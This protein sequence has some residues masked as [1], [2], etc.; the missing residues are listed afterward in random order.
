MNKWF[1]SI[2]WKLVSTYLLLI[3]VLL[4]PLNILVDASLT[5]YFIN[6]KKQS[7]LSQGTI[8]ADQIAPSFVAYY[9][10]SRFSYIE[11]VVKGL[12]LRI[13]SRV[14]VLNR[15]GDVIVDSYDDY[16][17]TNQSDITEVA[18][19]NSGVSAARL[20]IFESGR[21]IIYCAVP[22]YHEGEIVG[23][24]M[25]ASSPDDVY[26]RIAQ[27]VNSFYRVSI[28]AVIVTVL[29]SI[30]FADILSKPLEKLTKVVRQ[31]SKQNRNQKADINSHDEI[32]EL[33]DSV[34]QMIHKLYRVDDMRKQFVSNVSH[35]LRTPITSLKIISDTLIDSKP[36]QLSVYEDFM[37]DINSELE[38]LSRIIDTLLL[39]SKLDK[40]EFV[41]DYQ[42][43]ALDRLVLQCVHTLRPIAAK[44]EVELSTKIEQKI[45]LYCDDIKIRQCLINIIN[46]AIK[47]SPPRSRVEISLSLEGEY[48]LI[49]VTDNGIG[50]PAKDLPH[51]FDRFYRVDSA[52]ARS[53]GGSGLGL[54]I[55]L[56]VVKHHDGRIDVNSEEGVGSTF[57]VALPNRTELPS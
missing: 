20:Y 1:I 26:Q 17:G 39:L 53:T 7:L 24:I 42:L 35:E 38:R 3:I 32:G 31:V 40:D 47:Y 18:E 12:S 41:L 44:E 52:R 16:D 43:V 27:I 55:A 13:D 21:K 14:L 15:T 51:I 57:I 4:I 29:I 54:S 19:A 37:L 33:S 22:I 11:K 36:N 6:E 49:K 5:N 50:I 9:S 46:N 28:L 45:R 25:I 23:S 48:A 34:N 2:R 10:K 8:V 56:Q 30:L